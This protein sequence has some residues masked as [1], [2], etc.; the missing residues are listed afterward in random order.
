VETPQEDTEE[1]EDKEEQ[2]DFSEVDLSQL[3]EDDDNM[4]D[5]DVDTA[6]ANGAAD[7]R[8][9]SA[10]LSRDE[11]RHCMLLAASIRKS[12]RHIPTFGS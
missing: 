10:R 4:D 1:G 5:A 12:I 11:L 7:R 3:D 8:A 6:F 2:H 9:Q